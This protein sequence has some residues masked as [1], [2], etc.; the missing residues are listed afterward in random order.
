MNSVINKFKD[1]KYLSVFNKRAEAECF[2]AEGFASIL[3]QSRADSKRVI[4]SFDSSVGNDSFKK[5]L[6]AGFNDI[7]QHL[8]ENAEILSG[9]ISQK[10]LNDFSAHRF[11]RVIIN[12]S[13]VS[14]H[15]EG[16]AAKAKTESKS[17]NKLKTL[18]HGLMQQL[19][20]K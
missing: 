9:D 10:K 8:S 18:F 2:V 4:L 14:V 5:D 15:A 1:P 13:V 6:A 17:T 3:R 11:A 20:S 12:P 19:K 7:H 16:A